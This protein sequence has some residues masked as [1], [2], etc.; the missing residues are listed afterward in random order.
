MPKHD[1]PQI[2]PSWTFSVWL[3]FQEK[4][5]DDVGELAQLVRED[6]AWPGWRGIEGLEQYCRE[7]KLPSAL[8]AALRQAWSEWEAANERVRRLRSE[9][10]DGLA[11]FPVTFS[12]SEV[13][14]FLDNSSEFNAPP[15]RQ[16][17]QPL[18]FRFS[19]I[20][21]RGR[22]RCR[23]FVRPRN[24]G[25]VGKSSLLPILLSLPAPAPSSH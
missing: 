18:P 1:P 10:V 2:R 25:V 15:Q 13:P 12:D 21:N 22:V 11:A 17:P 8:I 19:S 24:I 20:R 3:A 5:K 23:A 6:L 4:R 14:L 7:Q 16:G 9:E